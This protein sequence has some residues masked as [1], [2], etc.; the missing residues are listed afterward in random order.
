MKYEFTCNPGVE[1]EGRTLDQLPM[2]NSFN[3]VVN[4]TDLSADEVVQRDVEKIVAMCNEKHGDAWDFIHIEEL[5]HESH[6]PDTYI[7][8][9]GCRVYQ[10]KQ[11]FG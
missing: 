4:E 6:W 9:V 5:Q 2:F 7:D 10:Q 3:Y 11:N 8:R 1:I